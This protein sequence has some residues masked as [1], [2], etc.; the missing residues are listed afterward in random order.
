VPKNLQVNQPFRIPFSVDLISDL[1][2][3]S[4][5]DFDWTDKATS[6][7]CVVAGNISDDL[8][9]VRDV[10]TRL[11]AC[12]RGIFYIEGALEHSNLYEY[13]ARIEQI[14]EICS[15]IDHTI[16]MHNHVVIL[17]NVAFTA[18]NGWNGNFTKYSCVEDVTMVSAYRGMDVAHLAHTITSLQNHPE[19]K[20][21]VIISNALPGKKLTL[22]DPNIVVQEEGEPLTALFADSASK[23]TT[24]MFGS[25]QNFVDEVYDDCRFVN[26]PQMVNSH[27]LP[28]RIVL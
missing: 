1:N 5:E 24:W 6:L 2:L 25:Y 15:R 3:A 19:V 22:N 27:Y 18:V 20:R 28:K 21:I 17:N 9:V 8:E 11:G 12:Y 26:N 16:Y 10:L 14:R 23:V 4:A 7:F 13:E